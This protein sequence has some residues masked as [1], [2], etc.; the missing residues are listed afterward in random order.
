MKFDLA[1]RMLKFI[2]ENPMCKKVDIYFGLRTDYGTISKYLEELKKRGLIKEKLGRK[3]GPN[4]IKR[5]TII[6]E[7]VKNLL[8]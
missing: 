6:E 1:I 2:K 5:Y 3:H 4:R 7:N 8:L